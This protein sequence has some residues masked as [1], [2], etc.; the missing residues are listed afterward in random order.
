MSAEHNHEPRCCCRRENPH[1]RTLVC[2]ACPEHG[3]FDHPSLHTPRRNCVT[4][5]DGWCKTCSTGD[6]PVYH[7]KEP[8]AGPYTEQE[9]TK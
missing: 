6:G 7:R 4:A 5:I 3:V 8:V 2:P 1:A 9:T